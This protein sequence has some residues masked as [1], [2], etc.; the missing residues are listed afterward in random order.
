MPRL[1]APLKQRFLLDPDVIFLNHGSFGACPRP[2]FECYQQWQRRLE[3]Q[4]VDFMI[5]RLLGYLQEART[6]LAAY[7]HTAADDLVFVPN[8]TF[9]VNVVARS[10]SLAPGDEI[11]STDH[12]YGACDKI[13]QFVC[14]KTGAV[15]KRQPIPLPLGSREQTVQQF[16]QGVTGRTRAIFISHITSST[17]VQFPIETI[18]RRA[19]QA[20]ILTI[21]D[22][23]HAPGQI[24]L[25]L[26]ALG[27][28]FY[29]GNC[30]KWMMA[31]KGAA[32]LYARPEVQSLIEPLVVS[33]GWGENPEFDVGSPFLD[34]LQWL[35]TNDPSAYLTVPEAIRFMQAHDWP[36]VRA[37][38]HRLLAETLERISA[39][40]G[41]PS[42]YPALNGF[43]EQMAVAELPPIPDLETLKQRLY[44]EYRI[45]VPLLNWQGRQFIRI[46][47]Q[48]YNT[49]DDLETL[50]QA[51]E[52]LLPVSF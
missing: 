27:A 36:A 32:F 6:H 12:E 47:V 13:W 37:R 23:A 50:L 21:V 30:H 9:G 14:R 48:G 10:L 26:G 2:V 43:F 52:K 35:G 44:A 46:S 28:D 34:N 38:C 11:L 39:L 18:L 7:L 15:Y 5:N 24:P 42:I 4:P 8:A 20:G 22:G 16:W 45:E 29:T 31:P 40:T 1:P 51:L 17:A 3:R 49:P 19:R 25:D 41:L 33:W